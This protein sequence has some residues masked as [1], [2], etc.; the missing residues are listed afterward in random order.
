MACRRSVG[1]ALAPAITLNRMYHC[2]PSAISRMPPRFSGIPEATKNAI[3]NGNRKFA[4]KLASSCT[5]GWASRL[6]RGFIPIQTPIGTQT[7]VAN[8]RITT[9]RAIVTAPSPN[10]S[11][12]APRPTERWM[13]TYAA[14]APTRMAATT[15]TVTATSS[16]R[17][18]TTGTRSGCSARPNGRV[19]RSRPRAI[20][21]NPRSTARGSQ[22]R[23]ITSST[24]LRGR[25]VGAVSSC[26]NRSAHAT[27]GR[28][29]RK[30][31]PSTMIVM[32]R[33]AQPTLSSCPAST[34][35]ATYA[36]TPGRA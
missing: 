14:T 27:S 36:P 31:T 25:S 7:T 16:A 24:T 4:G 18:R 6:I 30:F 19:A 1:I 29:N 21:R 17:L 35:A 5:T 15:S 32:V 2:E 10:A 22:E 28:Q 33:M 9:T 20:G 12:K 34:A 13:N 11:R 23:L 26:R 3:A 8:S